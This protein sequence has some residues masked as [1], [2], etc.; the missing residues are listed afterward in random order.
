MPQAVA[1]REDEIRTALQGL[2]GWDYQAN[3]LERVVVCPTYRA[4]LELLQRIGELAEAEDHHPD[5]ALN[6]MQLVIRY[7]THTAGGVTP[8][9]VAQAGKAEALIRRLAEAVR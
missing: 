4:G 5:L 7:R 1:L 6:Y 2:P 3:A 8:L 9:D